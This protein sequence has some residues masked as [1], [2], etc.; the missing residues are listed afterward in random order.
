MRGPVKA[1]AYPHSEVGL[2]SAPV[3]SADSDEFV[4]EIEAFP[5]RLLAD[6][7]LPVTL[8]LD[9]PGSPVP[10]CLTSAVSSTEGLEP[11]APQVVFS[12]DEVAALVL[13]IEADRLWRKE[14][15]GFCFEKWRRPVWHVSADDALAG[16]L[17]DLEQPAWSVERVLKRLGATLL[18]VELVG[19]DR[20]AA[21]IP[22]AA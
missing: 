11:L 16:A 5:A 3:G 18:R 6:L 7:P 1:P 9:I 17:P 10:V 13:G 22:K 4:R 8:W 12:R 15:L 2:R 21:P 14:L 20:R 19:R